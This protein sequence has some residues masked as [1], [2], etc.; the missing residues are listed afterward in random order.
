M[1]YANGTSFTGRW[2]KDVRVPD[3]KGKF[4]QPDGL[5]YE[6]T[7]DKDDHFHGEGRLQEANSV[8]EGTFRN[9][10]RVKGKLQQ[11]DGT[12]DRLER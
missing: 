8:F 12:L 2:A 5:F 4:T 7:F 11:K 10:K 1:T 9:G 3:S 6:G